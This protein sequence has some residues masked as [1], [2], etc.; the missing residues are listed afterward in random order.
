MA[1]QVVDALINGGKAS[2]APPLGPAL[3][4][5]GVNIGQVIA[6]INKKT[7]AFDGMQVPV[8]V[9]V[10][11]ETKEFTISVGTPPAS[12]LI[13]QEA[14]IKKASGKPQEDFVANLSM[15]QI[16]KIAQMKES[17]L[18]GKTLREQAREIM[19]TCQSMGVTIE[20]SKAQEA[21]KKMD[22]GAF[23]AKFA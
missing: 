15:E 20:G 5:L 7:A 14:G 13:K 17:G 6:E 10:D 22:E 23:D 9:E 11:T 2:A 18:T 12:A 16:I 4:P 1:K 8:A 19:G 3:G 21:F